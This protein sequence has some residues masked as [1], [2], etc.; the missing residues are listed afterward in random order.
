MDKKTRRAN[1]KVA[2]AEKY[3]YN[4]LYGDHKTYWSDKIGYG[5]TDL[6]KNKEE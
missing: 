1:A 5:V 4:L 2:A 6:K 3:I